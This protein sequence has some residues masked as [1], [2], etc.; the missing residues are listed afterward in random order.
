MTR[1]PTHFMLK[2]ERRFR[3][4]VLCALALLPSLAATLLVPTGPWKAI[5]LGAGVLAISC[6][7]VAIWQGL[8]L[9]RRAM[10][11]VE[12]TLG[13]SCPCCLAPLDETPGAARC[14]ACGHGVESLQAVQAYWQAKFPQAFDGARQ[15]CAGCGYS[16]VGLTHTTCPE[17][18]R[19]IRT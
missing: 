9:Q 8:R 14:N 16:L 13:R 1:A 12:E 6:N 17:C 7:L 5:G 3:F 15:T 18:G 10:R 4:G 2:A 19:R 11:H